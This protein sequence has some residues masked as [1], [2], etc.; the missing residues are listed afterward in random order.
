MFVTQRRDAG[1]RAAGNEVLA[2]AA[3]TR[4]SDGQVGRAVG[5][6]FWYF[7]IAF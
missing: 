7:A 4:L 6:K 5:L 2:A 3:G 1:A